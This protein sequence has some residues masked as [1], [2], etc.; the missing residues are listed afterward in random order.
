V[1]ID[2]RRRQLLKSAD[3]LFNARGIQSTDLEAV[4]HRAS[5]T[6]DD[7]DGC[8]ESKT[9]LIEAV[10]DSRHTTWIG[11]VQDA[12][13]EVDDP[14]DKILAIF[15]YL[16]RWFAEDTFQGCVFVNSYAELG[17]NE[18]WV[19]A[20]ALRHVTRFTTIVEDLATSAGLPRHTGTSIALLAEGAQTTAALTRSISPAREA[21]SAAALLIALYQ[22]DVEF[23]DF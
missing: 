9:E 11:H 19:A 21:K 17:R 22:T 20:M 14:R 16:E 13:D 2:D 8:F 5:L 18:P 10:L 1:L 3:Y 12:C 7:F 15:G 4:V 6:T 23:P